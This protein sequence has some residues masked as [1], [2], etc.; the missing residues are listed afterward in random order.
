MTAPVGLVS[1]LTDEQEMLV[2]ASVRFMDATLPVAAIRAV[3]D[4][5]PRDDTTYRAAAGELGWFG[6]LGDEAACNRK[7]GQRLDEASPDT[8]TAWLRAYYDNCRNC[9]SVTQCVYKEPTCSF[10]ECFSTDECCEPR[11]GARRPGLRRRL[12]D[13]GVRRRHLLCPRGFTRRPTPRRS[14]RP[15]G[16]G[17]ELFPRAPRRVRP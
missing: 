5:G 16:G 4:G 17:R 10:G 11:T 13:V 6:F 14:R 8:R 3:A 15:R 12:G 1:T 9:P 7:L 2:D